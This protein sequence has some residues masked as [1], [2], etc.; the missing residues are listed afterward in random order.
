MIFQQDY[1]RHK[2]SVQ[3]IMEIVWDIYAYV[4]KLTHNSDV[5][6]MARINSVIKTEEVPVSYLER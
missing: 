2:I 3:Y 4:H 6:Y 1:I 5:H